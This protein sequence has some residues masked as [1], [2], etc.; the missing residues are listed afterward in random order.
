MSLIYAYASYASLPIFFCVGLLTLFTNPHRLQDILTQDF[1]PK[2]FNPGLFNH[3]TLNPR[4]ECFSTSKIFYHV[5]K[6]LSHE[7]YRD[8]KLRGPCKENLHYLWKRAVRIAGKLNLQCKSGVELLKSS[9]LK[10]LGLKSQ[11]RKLGAELFGV[12]M[13]CNHLTVPSPAWKISK[14]SN[15]DS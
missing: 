6:F 4:V 14:L 3:E 9:W 15:L 10:M 13:F 12:K 1:Q 5:C 7:N 11:G 2:D 8:C